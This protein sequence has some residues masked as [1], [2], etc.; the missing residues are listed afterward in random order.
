MSMLPTDGWN[1]QSFLG[2]WNKPPT[3]G[4]ATFLYREDSHDDSS[5]AEPPAANRS[6][7]SLLPS[8]IEEA[9]GGFVDVAQLNA[10]LG[11]APKAGSRTRQVGNLAA[12]T[13][14]D[15]MAFDGR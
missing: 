3:G 12:R 6:L 14:Y 13:K 1:V 8:F 5:F 15:R 10:V 2:G 4:R 7:V 11:R 9:D